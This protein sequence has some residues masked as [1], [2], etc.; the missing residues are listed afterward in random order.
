MRRRLRRRC[1][2]RWSPPIRSTAGRVR[3]RSTD[4]GSTRRRSLATEAQYAEMWV[5]DATAM[6]ATR[7]PRRR[8][9]PYAGDAADADHQPGCARRSQTAR[10][11][12]RPRPRAA[13]ALP[14]SC[15]L[16]VPELR[17]CCSP[18]DGFLGTPPSSTGINGAVNTAA[19]FVGNAITD[20]GIAGPHAG[21]RRGAGRRRSDVV[22][23][24]ARPAWWKGPWCAR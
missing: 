18:L 4:P 22:P 13:T 16:A 8:Q 3:G 21:R 12:W 2:R 7:P 9:R 11:R 1:P 6:Y 23:D 14:P 19:W 17:A 15:S 24:A 10:C 5:Q 20:R